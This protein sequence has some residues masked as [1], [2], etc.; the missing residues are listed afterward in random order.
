MTEIMK[1]T[2]L[3]LLYICGCVLTGMSPSAA[4]LKNINLHTLYSISKFHSLTAIVCEGLEAASYTPSEEEKA[5]FSSFQTAKQKSI[6][7]NLLLDTERASILS[8]MEQNGIWYM[9]LKGVILKDM[10]PKIGLRQMADNDILFDE[11]YRERVRDWFAERGYEVEAYGKGNH[12]VYLKAPIYNYEMHV[13]LY[14]ES[15][16]EQWQDYYRAVKSRLVKNGDNGYGYHFTDEDFYIYFL[17]HGFKHFDGSGTGLRFLLDLYV[18][19]N[20]KHETLDMAYI[21]NELKILGIVDFER[22]CRE[23][24]FEVFSD[25][26]TFEFQGLTPEKQELLTY[27]ITSGTYGTIEQSVE[28]AMKKQGR[29]KY[30]LSRFFPGTSVLKLYNPI[31][32]HWWLLPLGWIYRAFKIIFSRP[33]RVKKEL[34]AIYKVKK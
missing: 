19:L 14:G 30:L 1:N 31:F 29:L 17:T 8:F 26:N 18:Y 22:N 7:K 6:R 5:C 16:S 12:D 34:R 27:F 9:P 32:R 15:H 11:S 33:E 10:Y 21:E 3:E 4:R 28:K 2:A 13:S 24:V 20:K 23:L 25:V